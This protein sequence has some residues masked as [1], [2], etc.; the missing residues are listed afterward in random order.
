MP[1]NRSGSVAKDADWKGIE[2]AAVA[3]GLFK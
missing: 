3:A 1:V 2:E